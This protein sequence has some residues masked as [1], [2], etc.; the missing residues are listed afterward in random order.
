MTDRLPRRTFAAH[1]DYLPDA[2]D[3]GIYV[4]DVLLYGTPSAYIDIYHHTTRLVAT[5]RVRH[6]ER[7]P[8]EKHHAFRARLA[9]PYA[10][11]EAPLLSWPEATGRPTS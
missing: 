5:V 1:Q 9:A 4:G 2:D 6:A 7:D 11:A 8:A 10:T 3:Y